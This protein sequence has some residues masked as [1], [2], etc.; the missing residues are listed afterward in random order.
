M[1]KENNTNEKLFQNEN[2]NCCDLLKFKV[3]ISYFNFFQ[4][5]NLIS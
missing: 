5:Y 1:K 4:V 3:Y 2:P